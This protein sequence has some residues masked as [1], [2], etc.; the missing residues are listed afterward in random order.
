[1]ERHT[2]NTRPLKTEDQSD[3][4]TNQ[5]MAGLLANPEKPERG[6][7][8]FPYGFQMEYVSAEPMISDF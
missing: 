2:G 1:M 6:K 3:T 8:G 4:L 7:E 5:G